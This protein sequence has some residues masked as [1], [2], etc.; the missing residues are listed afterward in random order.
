MNAIKMKYKL[1]KADETVLMLAETILQIEKPKLSG[2]L[3]SGRVNRYN[4][5]VIVKKDIKIDE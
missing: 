1:N 5:A 3:R 4:K 2:A